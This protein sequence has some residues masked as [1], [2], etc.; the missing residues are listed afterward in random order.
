MLEV[1]MGSEFEYLKASA[2]RDP[3]GRLLV[4]V[5]RMGSAARISAVV[6]EVD[7]SESE[8]MA[9]IA[10]AEWG[11]LLNRVTRDGAVY[12]TLTSQGLARVEAIM[13]PA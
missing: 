13:R 4:T 11:G 1:Q 2:S 6:T 9:A 7:L 12:L 3:I 10:E 8:C 5:H